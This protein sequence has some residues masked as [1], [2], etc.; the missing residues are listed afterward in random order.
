MHISAVVAYLLQR[1]R[2]TYF[3]RTKTSRITSRLPLTILLASVAR[4]AGLLLLNI[5][6]DKTMSLLLICR[7]RSQIVFF[8]LEALTLYAVRGTYSLTHNLPGNSADVVNSGLSV[9]QNDFN[10]GQYD[11]FYPVGC[12][13]TVTTPTSAL[14]C[15]RECG[16]ES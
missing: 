3:S 9:R 13:S 15:S 4:L 16:Y 1:L 5:L 14:F 11:Y 8:K 12:I 7:L 2:M 10:T 6:C